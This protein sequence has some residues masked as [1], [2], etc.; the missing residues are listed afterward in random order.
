MK[1]FF[2]I[3]FGGFLLSSGAF[4]Q[5]SVNPSDDFYEW[6]LIWENRNVIS[7][8]P[9]L[10]PYPANVIRDMLE[11]VIENGTERD[12]EI[13][14]DYYDKFFETSHHAEF[15][16]GFNFKSEMLERKKSDGSLEHEYDTDK[17][18]DSYPFL[19]GDHSF[20]DSDFVTM[21]Y[22][23]GLTARTAEDTDFMPMYSNSR[24]DGIYDGV[25]VGPVDTYIDIND[26]LA[27]GTRNVYAQ[28]GLY[29]SGFSPYLNEGLIINDTCY[30]AGH[31]SFTYAKEKLTYTQELSMIGATPSYDGKDY[32]ALSPDK[33]RAFHAVEYDLFEPLSFTFYESAVFGNRFD[34]TYLFPVP[35]MAAQN[36][37]GCSDALFMGLMLNVKPASGVAWV[38]DVA[39]DDFDIDQFLKLNF[40][41]KY[42]IAFRSGFII[43]PENS[44]VTKINFNYM[45]ITPYT[46]SHWQ[47]DSNEKASM[48]PGV[49]NYQN[50]TNS[51]IQM[52]SS[53]PP[54]SDAV[55]FAI[56]FKPV[57]N[58]KLQF[59]S[60][61]MRHA[62]IC[63]SL[64]DDESLEYLCAKPKV[65]STRG[66]V[67]TH[68]MFDDDDSTGRHVDT[69]WD[70]L[71][72]LNQKNQMYMIQAG[73]DAEYALNPT[74]GG[75]RVSFKTGCS[76]EYIHNEGVD[77][78]LFPA[79]KV[80]PNYD[81]NGNILNYTF[82]GNVY[83]NTD[84]GKKDIV[85]QMKDEWKSKLHD[86]INFY[87]NLGFC[88]RM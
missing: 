7:E 39:V 12:V 36:V 40:D 85:D 69:A 6:A 3:V 1:K 38:T 51:G 30:H 47:Y 78:E 72:W 87:F 19:V 74:S 29:R 61:F 45:F 86:K 52:G 76:V 28:V 70:H 81:A 49:V 18:I 14:N 54:N 9:L 35:F 5:V 23:L 79:G 64:T 33:F 53:F 66:N 20:S 60:L 15:S 55:K 62:N 16:A 77:N 21:G 48:T 71:N 42:R 37:G 41:S 26:V 50:Y 22:S 63:E 46:F 8:V 27:V 88:I 82:D 10:R 68:S 11:T 13:A 2:G 56:D 83:D 65:Y 58:L 44:F 84:A 67:D 24:R 34:A 59:T 75:T 43:T 32:T 4:A 17:M 73:L 25:E 31:L 57:K 80:T